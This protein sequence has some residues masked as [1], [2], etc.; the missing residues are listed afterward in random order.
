MIETFFAEGF[1]LCLFVTTIGHIATKN[2]NTGDTAMNNTA[3]SLYIVVEGDVAEVA[4]RPGFESLGITELCEHAGALV[5]DAG[6][7]AE[8]ITAADLDEL[9]ANIA[10][11]LDVENATDLADYGSLVE[12][13][14]N[15]S[16]VLAYAANGE[17]AL[18]LADAYDRGEIAPGNIAD[19]GIA[20]A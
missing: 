8:L 6:N 17:H 13:V 15:V 12:N 18:H 19:V 10:H 2:G 20:L 4:M 14:R 9:A 1:A 7:G 16:A 11:W 5:I 3:R